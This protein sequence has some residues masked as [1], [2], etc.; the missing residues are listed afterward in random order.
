MPRKRGQRKKKD[1]SPDYVDP[2]TLVLIT[3]LAQDE[4]G[5]VLAGAHH[6]QATQGDLGI[7]TV[8]L[9]NPT[10]PRLM[11]RRIPVD[12]SRDGSVESAP[13]KL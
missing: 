8:Y 6:L 7:G 2:A 10:N 5:T 1:Q 11:D 3:H 12:T 13:C 4:E 9:R